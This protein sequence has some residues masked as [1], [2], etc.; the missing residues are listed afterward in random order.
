MKI[1]PAHHA[2]LCYAEWCCDNRIPFRTVGVMAADLARNLREIESATRDLVEWG[3][4]S[5][6]HDEGNKWHIIRLGDGRETI[7]I[8]KA[9]CPIP[10]MKIPTVHK[11]RHAV[12]I[13]EPTA[14]DKRR[15]A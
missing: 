7:P 5:I 3:L 9:R 15:V 13:V 12:D 2:I 6:R 14:Y 1:R 11:R 8:A 4:M 10:A